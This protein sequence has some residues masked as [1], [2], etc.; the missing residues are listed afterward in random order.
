MQNSIQNKSIIHDP[1]ISS[2]DLEN[3]LQQLLQHDQVIYD[4]TS[5]QEQQK[6]K[7]E[8]FYQRSLKFQQKKLESIQESIKQNWIKQHQELQQKPQISKKSDLLAKSMNYVPVHKRSNEYQK[9]KQEKLKNI[10]K[11]QEFQEKVE[12]LQFPYSPEIMTS[13]TYQPSDLSQNLSQTQNQF[14]Q[15]QLKWK[16]QKEHKLKILKKILIN[17]TLFTVKIINQ[18]LKLSE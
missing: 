11:Q 14:Y 3:L 13:Q 4:Q 17:E 7:F 8:E 9:Q 15:N 12:S 18:A 16:Q 5:Q 2:K 10:E 6:S 1:Q